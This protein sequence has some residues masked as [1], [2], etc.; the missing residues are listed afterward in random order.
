MREFAEY[1]KKEKKMADNTVE[2]YERD[3][4]S[5]CRFTEK[6]GLEN[7]EEAANA[8]V[9]AYLMHLKQEGK[10]A[11]YSQPETGSDP[12]MVSVSCGRGQNQ[13]KSRTGH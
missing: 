13:Q 8:E 6:W 7:P 9:V 2:A 12:D 4:R 3:V 10:S 5:F 11:R 1:L